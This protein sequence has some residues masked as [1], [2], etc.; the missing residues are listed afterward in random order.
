M[1]YG[2]RSSRQ[3]PHDAASPSRAPIVER[4]RPGPCR[5]LGPEPWTFAKWRKRTTTAD[6]PMGQREPK[7]TEPTPT[8][9]AVV[10]EF[11]RRTLLPLDDV[12]D[13]LKGTVADLSRSALHRCLQ[14]RGTSRLPAGE[15]TETRGRFETHEIGYVRI[16]ACEPRR[17]D[18]K[19][20]MFLAIDRVS[21]FTGVEFHDHAG[22]MEG[23]AF[24][25][26]VVHAFPC[27]IHIVLTD[28]GMAFADLPQNR[29]RLGRAHEPD[30]QGRNHQG[31]PLPRPG[32]LEDSHPG[33][34]HCLQL[35]QDLKALRWGTL[36]RAIC[37]AWANDPTVFENQ[38]APPHP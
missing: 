11:R 34:R 29:E 36:Y 13:C 20:V 32:K 8:A 10:L 2:R 35:R 14:R 38:S 9:D 17:T 15:G 26:N 25:R 28:D 30:N 31:L 23:A 19:L 27:R 5:T 6:A 37:D 21:N 24:L 7:S 12:L 33:L 16:D 3:R 1:H 18:G 22:K 4:N